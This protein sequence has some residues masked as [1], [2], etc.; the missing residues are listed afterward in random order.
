MSNDAIR[1]RVIGV[2]KYMIDNQATLRQAAQYFGFSK[3]T[4]HLDMVE[5]LADI[6]RTLYKSI[7]SLL[8]HHKLI[9]HLRGGESTKIRYTKKRVKV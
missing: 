7:Q 3:S 8:T 9:R 2:A 6:D 5:R 1:S 4:I